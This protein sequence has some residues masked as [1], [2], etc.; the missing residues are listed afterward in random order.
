MLPVLYACSFE[1]IDSSYLHLPPV[2]EMHFM[3]P[4][5]AADPFYDPW[6]IPTHVPY[7]AFMG[8]YGY[9]PPP[10]TMT[11]NHQMYFSAPPQRM[12]ISTGQPATKRKPQP[13]SKPRTKV[14][15]PD[16]R[17]KLSKSKIDRDRERMTKFIQKK[18]AI[19]EAASLGAGESIDEKKDEEEET[20]ALETTPTCPTN[21]ETCNEVV[22]T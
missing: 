11:P 12:A 20:P 3:N 4:R 1:N 16:G 14:Y 7:P 22:S 2:T 9:Y 10:T 6:M 19:L 8:P 5:N 15:L 18:S 21:N 13:Y 17:R